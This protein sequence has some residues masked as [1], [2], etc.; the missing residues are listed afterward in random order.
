MSNIFNTSTLEYYNYGE[1]NYFQPSKA[2]Y[3]VK[4]SDKE[5][6]IITLEKDGSLFA[7]VGLSLVG[8][9]LSLID[10]AHDDSVL[11]EID[12]P[13]A[14][15]IDNCHFD[16]ETNSI[17]FDII[18]LNGEVETVELDVESLVDVYEAGQGVEIGDKDPETGKKSISIKLASG[19]DLLQLSDD[20]LSISDKIATDEEVEGAVSGKADV[21]Y[22]DELF[23]SVSGLTEDISELEGKVDSLEDDIEKIKDI[24]GTD[25]D[26]PNLD[27]RID[28]KADLDDLNDLEDEVGELETQFNLISAI[29]D[30]LNDRV[31]TLE[32]TVIDINELKEDVA[33]L[34]GSV[35]SINNTIVD[36]NSNIAD[37]ETD[38]ENNKTQIVKVTSGLSSNVKEAYVLTNKLG[39][40]LG[41]QINIYNDSTIESI[42]YTTVGEHGEE[43]QFLKITYVS[44][45][46]EKRVEYVDISEM[47]IETEFADGFEIRDGKVYIKIDSESDGYLSVS[48]NGLKLSGVFQQ[49]VDLINTDNQQW[50]AITGE[51][52]RA[53]EV[54]GQLWG[55]INGEISAR[56]SG[57]TN[58]QEQ[59]N[60]IDSNVDDLR[61]DLDDEIQNRIDGDNELASTIDEKVNAEK[62]RA[63]SAERAERERA[64]SAERE[65]RNSVADFDERIHDVEE[66]QIE[67]GTE[68]TNLDRRISGFEQSLAE[69][70]TARIEADE[71]LA[72]AIAEM[73][74]KYATKQYVDTKDSEVREEAISTA[75][76]SAITYTDNEVDA[77]EVE[78]K[79]YCDSGHTELQ[80]AISTNATKINAISNLKGVSGDDTSNYDDSGNGILDVLH[81]E[82]HQLEEEIGYITNPTLEK[83]NP[84]YE[85]AF[86][87]Y[88]VSNTGDDPADRTIFSVGI[89]T[90]D[91]ERKNALEIREDGS[92][93]MWVEG[94][95]MKI[96]DLIGMLAHEIY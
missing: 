56:E 45:T 3:S 81:R 46:G 71:E 78:L 9:I 93:Y 40:V 87:T 30:D 17:V 72:E 88:N 22:V 10:K 21:E 68:V 12:F 48:E 15:H 76:S 37:L 28:S 90:S 34:S 73:D 31:E 51:T 2:A 69:E 16:E 61:N 84:P 8:N 55:A 25:E 74:G 86:G 58:L 62:E 67:L 43:G 18:T 82:F 33:E 24:I 29:T 92:I 49:F 89:G 13:N 26:D 23:D 7:C 66:G 57:D 38:V 11:A 96:N 32:E 79:Q 6:N 14:G 50:A 20:G 36:I 85:T 94:D 54:E 95:F 42:E 52:A 83:N 19:E 35:E 80:Q 5:G 91:E 64:E 39:E 65:I 1:Q 53:Q 47:V 60:E 77:L 44:S 27:E 63:E 75:I 70:T 59:I 41:E 4:V